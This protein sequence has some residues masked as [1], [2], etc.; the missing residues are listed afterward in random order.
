MASIRVS[1]AIN[2]TP[3]QVWAVVETIEDHVEWMA[4]AEAIR[5]TGPSRRGV[6]TTFDCDTK[7]G[8]FRLTDAME[9]TE[10]DDGHAMG[11]AHTGLVIGS[12][13]FTLRPAGAGRTEFRWEEELKFPFWMGGPLRNPVGGRVLAAIWRRNLKRLK[14]VVEATL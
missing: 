5:F 4:D 9:I 2:A 1:T 12:G 7:V 3:A 6:G 10:W 11:V 8:P 13:R 14:A